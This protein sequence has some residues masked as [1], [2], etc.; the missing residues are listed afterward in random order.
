VGAAVPCPNATR[1]WVRECGLLG[2]K[3]G[4]GGGRSGNRPST[5]SPG[6][7]R[8]IADPAE[9]ARADSMGVLTNLRSVI[10]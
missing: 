6:R 5:P 10:R 7:A 4:R 2:N 8:W 1:R 3:L 9:S